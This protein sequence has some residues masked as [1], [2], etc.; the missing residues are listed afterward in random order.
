MSTMLSRS[1]IFLSCV[2]GQAGD[3]GQFF[4]HIEVTFVKNQKYDI[5]YKCVNIKDLSPACPYTHDKK[6]I[7]RESMVDIEQVYINQTYF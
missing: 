1:M 3:K 2:Y 7:L 5:C 4:R 6:I